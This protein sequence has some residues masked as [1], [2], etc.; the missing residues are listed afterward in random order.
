MKRIYIR[1][2]FLIV[3]LFICSCKNNVVPMV[4]SNSGISSEKLL[5]PENITAICGKRKITLMWSASSS[6]TYYSIYA[7]PTQFDNFVKIGESTTTSFDYNLAPGLTRF[8]KIVAEDET[9]K[10]S[11]DESLIV[12]GYSLAKPI[13]TTIDSYSDNN[14][15]ISV[16]SW[17]M[18]NIEEYQQYIQYEIRCYKGSDLLQEN[19]VSGNT[20]T[21]TS[22]EFRNLPQN[23]TVQFEIT[24][25]LSN[26]Q[27]V[28]EISDK[29]DSITLAR[30]TPDPVEELTVS[31]G[32]AKD[33]CEISFNLPDY[34]YLRNEKSGSNEPY[35]LYFKISRREEG[36]EN[37]V[38]V[39][40]HLYFDG[41]TVTKP[42]A[43][44]YEPGA[45]CTYT[46]DSASLVAGKKYEYLVQSFVETDIEITSPVHSV[47]SAVGWTCGYPSFVTENFEY[48][49]DETDT[50]KKSAA[51]VG[52]K[53]SWNNFGKE[54]GYNFLLETIRK[55]NRSSEDDSI[56][57]YKL[58]T[59]T[60]ELN[61]YTKDF[62]LIADDS[63]NT[64]TG[65]YLFKL[66]V[67]KEEDADETSGCADGSLI[68]AAAPGGVL[69][70]SSTSLPTLSGFAVTSGYKDKVYLQWDDETVSASVSEY[71][72]E[73]YTIDKNGFKIS[74]DEKTINID[75]TENPPSG[76][77]I[78]FT[79][80]D[81]ESGKRYMYTLSAL[82]T[83][84]DDV[85]STPLLGE[86]L[87]TANP[88]FDNENPKHDRIL[89]SW[90]SVLQA[91]PTKYSVKLKDGTNEI[92]S[93]S[94]EII[95]D[96][97]ES[98]FTCE[99]IKP[100]GYDDANISGKNLTVEV[101][102]SNEKDSTV[103]VG[104][105]VRTLGPKGISPVATTASITDVLNPSATG[106]GSTT[107]IKVAWNAIAGAKKYAVKRTRY[108]V[109]DSSF[110]NTDA[111]TDIYYVTPSGTLWLEGGNCKNNATVSLSG[112]QLILTDKYKDAEGSSSGWDD[113]Q[114]KIAWGYP[115][116]YTI[117]PL[118]SNLT[119]IDETGK[120][121]LN[122]EESI[123]YKN[124]PKTTG[125]CL[126]YG[127]NVSA[128]KSADSYSITV[129]W[130]KP[131]GLRDEEKN[132][133]VLFYR[134]G[135]NDSWTRSV[136]KSS[137]DTQNNTFVFTPSGTDTPRT[138]VY[139]FAVGYTSSTP[140]HTDL[141]YSQK[142]TDSVSPT[143]SLNKGYTYSLNLD[144]SPVL[145]GGTLSLK[146]KFTWTL[147]DYDERAVG[148]DKDSKIELMMFNNDYV[149]VT[150][151]DD[152][153]R[154]IASVSQTGDITEVPQTDL[155][156]YNIAIS[157]KT[158][159][160]FYVSPKSTKDN[161]HQWY[162]GLLKVQRDYRH[163]AKLICD[164]N[165]AETGRT[166]KLS[167]ADKDSAKGDFLVYGYRNFT[168]AEIARMACYTLAYAF[169]LNDGGAANFSSMGTFKY[170]GAHNINSSVGNGSAVFSGDTYDTWG[171]IFSVGQYYFNFSFNE[172]NCSS[173]TV[174][175]DIVT[176][177]VNISL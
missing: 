81:I 129:S 92:I 177:P 135:E 158:S 7:A 96:S 114:D 125:S 113:N 93:E 156:K 103:N 143:E 78:Y 3:L 34:S 50:S 124:M 75:L 23:T 118:E 107:E 97:T 140:L 85:P 88:V 141:S 61:S 90:E 14:D 26:E 122:E 160:G 89:V 42:S 29:L 170:G 133:P 73:R 21:D 117:I 106:A 123:S 56:K 47:T 77:K 98:Y 48:S 108:D 53:S 154:Q 2:S 130:D 58:F 105:T 165:D 110:S 11:S 25:F 38:S 71:N 63:G 173:P 137:Y 52:F 119:E 51:S 5:P 33:K 95:P 175:K 32:V 167:W 31:T 70:S 80:T 111:P 57:T 1:L 28:S 91:D 127:H 164:R 148:P 112:T 69:V 166:V 62:N 9:T 17:Y 99:I 84:G 138:E 171:K 131:Y 136:L 60:D 68:S 24:A 162:N 72:I 15:S 116:Q 30:Q 79:D 147:W 128:T 132:N 8:F 169:Y 144:A 36:S 35:P 120:I 87:G 55:T 146:E 153:W 83:D 102:S 12:K 172:Y 115:Y 4:N 59:S 19:L 20:L 142:K 163:F 65:Y 121:I 74:G 40:P 54:K 41:Q 126:G 45:K 37:Y 44:N 46:D 39:V 82:T 149:A 174:S 18:S 100:A 10:K 94:C 66:H 150:A 152:G 67:V 13:I 161:S 43:D 139:Y 157:N 134:K 16:V 27:N 155:D 64:D 6:A 104:T 86:T 22:Y 109:T 76:N 145:E 101:T 49:Y 151:E 159:N 176:L 168:D